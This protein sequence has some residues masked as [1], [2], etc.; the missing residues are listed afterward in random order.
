MTRVLSTP[1][2]HDSELF[3]AVPL[4][5]SG[6]SRFRRPR[7]GLQARAS[8]LSP[9]LVPQW[10]R[11]VEETG[12]PAR[13]PCRPV[14]AAQVL[15]VEG[16]PLSRADLSPKRHVCEVCTF[17]LWQ[18][19][20]TGPRRCPLATYALR[21]VMLDGEPVELTA[22]QYMVLCELA[23]HAPRTLTHAVLL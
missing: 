13:V 12:D 8:V 9:H 11:E 19:D 23:V 15:D 16:V 4:S 7:G 22:T 17:P 10:E 20:E 3:R 2:P 6:H 14:C 18:A 1:M 21:R 5:S